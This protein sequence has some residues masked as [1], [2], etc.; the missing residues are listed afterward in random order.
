MFRILSFVAGLGLAG[1]A[2]PLS[3]QDQKAGTES[4]ETAGT[5]DGAASQLDFGEPIEQGPRIGDR[6]LKKEFGD[7]DLA[8]LRTE[9]DNDPCSLM[10]ILTDDEGNPVSEV[11]LFRI[12]GGSQAVAGATVIV[13]LET[14]LTADL[15]IAVDGAP[16]KRYSYKF[17]NQIGCVAQIGLTQGDVDAFKAG[18]AATVTIVPAPAPDQR[19]ELTMSLTGF[20]AGFNAVDVVEN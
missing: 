9:T 8:C 1:L 3:A 13:P 6:Y 2:A 14:L 20:S 19:V 7:W 12:G 15:Q 4:T 17:C 5:S 18:R 10:Q 11:S 16:G